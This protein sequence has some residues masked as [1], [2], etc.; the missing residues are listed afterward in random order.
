[1][2]YLILLLIL[3]V[4]PNAWAEDWQYRLEGYT[5]EESVTELGFIEY[6]SG[7]KY[8][9]YVIT[10]A[11]NPPGA[12]IEVDDECIGQAP[13]QFTA[14]GLRP[15]A[16]TMTVRAIPRKPGY[17]VQTKVIKGNVLLPIDIYF[18]MSLHNGYKE[19]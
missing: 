5:E 3:L 13:V 16:S 7:F 10:V 8:F 17:Y 9:D 19:R 18:D 14:N 2:R 1:M 4:V 6:A 15:R 11:S 12:V